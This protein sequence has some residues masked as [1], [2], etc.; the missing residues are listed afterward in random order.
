MSV[1]RCGDCRHWRR[2]R[3]GRDFAVPDE[4]GTCG[5]VEMRRPGPDGFG[6]GAQALAEDGSGYFAA[7]LSREAFGCVL[8]EPNPGPGTEPAR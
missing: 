3:D 4:W 7:L 1:G 8:H 2:G 5:L 6:V